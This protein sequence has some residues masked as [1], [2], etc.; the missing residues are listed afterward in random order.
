MDKIFFERRLKYIEFT[1]QFIATCSIIIPAT[2]YSRVVDPEY[3]GD[4]KLCNEQMRPTWGRYLS[5]KG[6]RVGYFVT[7]EGSIRRVNEEIEVFETE[8]MAAI[9]ENIRKRKESKENG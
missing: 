7:K 5:E 6:G 9:R 3:C 4:Y 2:V 1:G 8:S